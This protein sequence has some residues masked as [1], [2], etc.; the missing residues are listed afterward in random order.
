MTADTAAALAAD[1]DAAFTDA[2]AE[3]AGAHH[4]LALR[5]LGD[6]EDARE[7]LQEAW[8]R[9][10][11]HRGS[12]REPAALHGWLRAIVARECYRLLRRRAL[13][14]WFPFGAREPADPAPAPDRSVADAEAARALRA[15][16]AAL[17]P[18]QRLAWG[19]RFEEGW[20]VGEIAAVMEVSPDTVKTHLD[21]ALV[22]LRRRLGASD[23]L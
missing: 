12:V 11:R 9:A 13:R 6:A 1:P 23:G 20:S 18:K 3:A 16:A 22:T 2:L 7:A 8:F 14:R 4:A 5:L 15:A 10:W 19:L 17:P 21:R